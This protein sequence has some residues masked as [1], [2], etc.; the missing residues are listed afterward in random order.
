MK[1]YTLEEVDKM[2]GHLFERFCSL[3]L[4]ECGYERTEVTPGSGD[5]GIDVIA[6][7]EGIKYGIQCKCYSADI[8]NKAVQEAYSGREFYGCHLGVVI[9]NRFFTGS[10]QELAT[11]NRIL[12]W[13]RNYLIGL[14]KNA[15][16]FAE[17][18]EKDDRTSNLD[19]PFDTQHEAD[20]VD[21]QTEYHEIQ[22]ESKYDHDSFGMGGND[23]VV[24]LQRYFDRNQF[25][26]SS[27]R[28]RMQTVLSEVTGKSEMEVM[29]MMVDLP[30]Q[31]IT[32]DKHEEA[33]RIANLL[34][35]EK[36]VVIIQSTDEW[37]KVE[38]TK[39]DNKL[40]DEYKK[41]DKL[42]IGVMIMI[43]PI[44]FDVY[45]LSQVFQNL[46]DLPPMR[47]L[48]VCILGLIVFIFYLL[49]FRGV[50]DSIAKL[51]AKKKELEK[52]F[53]NV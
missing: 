11:R 25:L 37:G 48:A 41:K 52:N 39:I 19:S 28:T 36:C 46:D 13:D 23:Y 6:Y 22:P 20:G 8:G 44:C 26:V 47:Y 42:A 7:K 21:K 4:L 24:V 45:V 27:F 3:L 33:E 10:A 38:K 9:T 16:I 17:N 32:C 50:S 18:I 40:R 5:Q 30:N 12:L 29:K 35:K 51:E 31:I 49:A 43:L 1:K 34:R 14:M 15:G 53:S 2:D